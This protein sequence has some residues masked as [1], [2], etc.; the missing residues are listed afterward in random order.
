MKKV[1]H[2]VVLSLSL[3]VSSEG[4]GQE[5]VSKD[6]DFPLKESLYKKYKKQIQAY[7]KK[8]FEALFFEFFQKQND[9][10]LLLNKEEYYTYTIKI[11]AYSE[12]LGLLYKDQKEESQR[13]K[14]E[15]F[16]KKYSDYLVF[17]KQ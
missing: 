6:V 2:V 10:C 7:D 4:F 16:D 11:A 5:S 9:K 15:W 13:T 12:R 8:E 14:Q 17:K 1:F 3:L